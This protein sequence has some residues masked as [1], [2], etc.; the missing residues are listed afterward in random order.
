MIKKALRWIAVGLATLVTILFLLYLNRSDPYRVIPGKQ[1]IGEEATESIDDWNFV[2]QH[3][4]VTNEVRPSNPYSVH[5]G[6]V[7]HEG[8]LYIPAGKGSES[9]WAQFLLQDPNMRIRVG[10]KL[11]KVR[12]TRVEDPALVSALHAI[13]DQ[14]NPG[15]EEKTPEEL[16][17]LARFWFFRI[18]S[19]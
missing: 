13:R 11:Y 14:R 10:D 4:L 19:R 7:V 1:L 15:Q 6:Y 2:L 9:R 12:A 16:A 8:V 17:R 5:T 3:R 18:D